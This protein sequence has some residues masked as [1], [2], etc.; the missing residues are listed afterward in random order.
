MSINGESYGSFI[1]KY[2]LSGYIYGWFYVIGQLVSVNPEFKPTYYKGVNIIKV[3]IVLRKIAFSNHW[4][5]IFKLSNGKY[6]IVQF[7]TTGKIGLSDTYNSLE[8]A[9]METWG[10]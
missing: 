6:G 3:W 2:Y 7:D 4:A 9:S 5:V 10:D 8:A 1:T